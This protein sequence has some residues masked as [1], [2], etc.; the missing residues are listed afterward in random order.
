MASICDDPGGRRRILFVAPDG[1]RR[2]LYLGRIDRRAAESI[3]LRIEAMLASALSGC[4]LDGE[5]ARWLADLPAPLARKLAKAGL[6][7]HRAGAPTKVTLGEFL[8]GYLTKRT[9]AKPSTIVHWRHTV[10]C[11]VEFFGP[12]KPLD[13]I[14]PGDAVDF[15]R[16]LRAGAR[17]QRRR[18]EPPGLAGATVRKRVSNAKQFFQ[19]AVA[20][21]LIH[22]NPFGALKGSVRPNRSRD[23]F[24]TRDDAQR[25]LD[26]CPDAQWRL[27]FALSR[28]GGLR[29][30]SEHLAL[31]WSD[32]DWERDRIR[33]HSP[34]TEHHE[35]KGERWIPLFPELRGPLEK[36]G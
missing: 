21:E 28:F 1:K 14:T 22:K 12:G 31:R 13:T 9:D 27:L 10:R 11:L 18:N 36:C 8:D 19:D 34:K 7:A 33:I 29:C 17:D 16:F 3:K 30:P 4:P 23:Y 25:I 15:E 32:V 20:R 2:T 26:A 35:G 24:L 5:T 6:I